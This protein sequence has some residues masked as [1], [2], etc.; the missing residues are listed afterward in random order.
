MVINGDL[1]SGKLTVCILLLNMAHLQLIYPLQMVIFYSYICL[2][3]G[4][5]DPAK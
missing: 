2:P 1:L 5:I 3:E 4:N